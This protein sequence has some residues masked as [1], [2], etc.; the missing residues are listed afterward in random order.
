[1]VLLFKPKTADE[2]R[3]SYCSSDVCSSDLAV[4]Q[5]AADRVVVADHRRRAGRGLRQ[6]AQAQ[7]DVQG[8]LP[9]GAARPAPTTGGTFCER[10]RTP[11]AARCEDRRVGNECVSLV[12]IEWCHDHYKTPILDNHYRST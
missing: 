1:M 9:D 2:L 12:R 7:H 6:R 5:A 4:R 11:D 3:I 10:R 8:G